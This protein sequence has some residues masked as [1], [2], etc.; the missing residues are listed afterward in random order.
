MRIQVTVT[1]E[2]TKPS[3]Y[4]GAKQEVEEYAANEVD[5]S[6]SAAFV[7]AALRALADDLYTPTT[8]APNFTGLYSDEFDR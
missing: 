8:K 6:G 1:G 5:L 7:A 3:P 2:R 4:V